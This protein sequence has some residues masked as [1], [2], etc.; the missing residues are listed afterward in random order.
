MKDLFKL[1]RKGKAS[2][3]SENILLI[4]ESGLFNEDWY[5]E[6]NPDVAESGESPLVHFYYHGFREGRNPSYLFDINWYLE[7]HS[8][9]KQAGLNPLIHYILHGEMEGRNPSPCVDIAYVRRQVAEPMEGLALS[10]FYRHIAAEKL[11]PLPEFNTQ[12]YLSANPDVE[13]SGMDPYF[14]FLFQGINEGRNPS[15]LFDI[16]KY[17]A[18]NSLSENPFWHYLTVGKAKGLPI[19]PLH[20]AAPAQ[21]GSLDLLTEIV[22]YR[23]PGEG[24][25]DFQYKSRSRKA[26][27]VKALA[28]YLPQF[29]PF[30]ENSEWWGEGFT[31]WTNVTRGLPRFKGHYQPHLPRDLGYYD[32]RL[33][34]TLQ[35]QAEMALAAGL[36]GFCFYHYWF[37]GKRLMDSP[38]NMLMENPDIELPFCILWA[39]ENW[40]RTWD[41]LENNILIAQDYRDEDD[42]AFIRDLGRHF[43]DP[44]YIRVD[45]RPLFFIY[46]PGI[47][48]DAVNRIEKWRKLSVE[49]LGET[50]LFFMAQ[51]FGD[52][53][54]S[55]FGMDG[56][57]EFPPHKLAQ[58]LDSK[59]QELGLVDPGFTGHYPLYDEL[60]ERSL[61]VEKPNFDLIRAVTP[62]WDNEAR[63]PGRGMGFIDSTPEKYE[64][65]LAS[66]VKYA[67]ANPITG[68]ESFVV[69][70]AWNEWAEGAHL[71]PDVYWGSAYLNATYRAVHGLTRQEG[72]TKLV[73]VGHDAYKHGAQLLTLN[74]FKTLVQDF[75]ID[76]ELVLLDGGPLVEDYQKIGKTHVAHG[77]IAIF[78]DIVKE[79]TGRSSVAHAIC[80]TTVT[81]HCTEVLAES[82]LKVISLVHELE[83]LI[84]EYALEDRAKAIAD[85]A[86]SVVFASS[87]VRDSFER[88]V[89]SIGDK[90]VV[91]PQ[92][93]YQKLQPDSN[94]RKS[95]R[96]K[97]NLPASAKIVVNAGFADLRKGFDLFVNAA[98]AA[99]AKSTDYH[100]VWLGN[101]EP[102]LKNWILRDIAGSDL[103]AHLHIVPFTNEISLYLQGA[104][105]FAMTSREDPFP[106]VVLE[107]LALGTP[108]VGF[109][110][111]G[112]FVELLSD[113]TNGAV[114]PM[115]D[116]DALVSAIEQQIANDSEARR[117][118]RRAWAM[119]TF[120]WKDYVFGLVEML[121]P[122]LRRVSVVV[123]NYN[124]ENHIGPRLETIFAQNYPVYEVIVLDDKS[125]DDSV[126]VI[127]ATADV[128]QRK[129]ELIVND[130]NSG[131]VF[132][133]WDKGARLAKGELLWIAEADD[134]ASPD[135]ISELVSGDDFD[136]AYSDSRQVDQNGALLAESYNYY[137]KEF[138]ESAFTHSFSMPGRNFLAEFLAVKNVIMN[139][140][141]VIF[142]TDS[143]C[144]ALDGIGDDLYEYSVA[145]DWFLYS[146][147]LAKENAQI[148]FCSKSLN[149]H[150]R[151]QGSVTHSLKAEKHFAEIFSVQ[152][153][154]ASRVE[155]NSSIKKRAKLHLKDVKIHLNLA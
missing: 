108:V 86:T 36:H 87:F 131:S 134:L 52:N 141:G 140:S 95:L 127:E 57:V 12:Y 121:M 23:G 110:N 5:K 56:A 42:E 37:N 124:Y 69:I 24:Y 55:V 15:Q 107:S 91:K 44:R 77:D 136:L 47:I 79:I 76:V 90:A 105:V 102:G 61:E 93:I 33:K 43:A 17:K 128:H 63:K 62:S 54:P 155:V 51:A 60:V 3:D 19:R 4:H 75:G 149:T 27:K 123:P 73:L 32:L 138:G 49:L 35:A 152:Q 7:T 59:A 66:M 40:T 101:V 130:K 38:V 147:L 9:V 78:R 119:G 28:Y 30:K 71:E 92:G 135:F 14:H 50:P 104:D 97:L 148:K 70:N 74:I 64:R 132:R 68:D 129:I 16:S 85:N 94:S 142:K 89:G 6:S 120:D 1:G 137:F 10:Y 80:N 153:D 2:S 98:R 154:V 34:D 115:G 88:V 82:G 118:T 133:Q 126:S 45:G 117:T 150:R 13:E 53:D 81:G 84:K 11:S 25:E 146:E 144:D 112:G 39:N 113:E 67:E 26:A 96:K 22:R 145:G 106:S 116:V 48:P 151:H 20:S 41:G 109:Q 29:H 46:R 18:E 114:V 125:S 99:L 58:G 65:W 122:E 139:V 8:D 100:F 31:E 72:K 83:T 21:D 111:G 103:E 143:L